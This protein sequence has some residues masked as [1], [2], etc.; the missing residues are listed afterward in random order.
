MEII[1][2]GG[3]LFIITLVAAVLLGAVNSITKPIIETNEKAA[4]EAAM[5]QVLPGIEEPAFSEELVTGENKGVT[6]YYAVTS[7]KADETAAYVVFV[8]KNGDQ[9]IVDVCVGLTV[10]GTV[11]KVTVV[12]HNETPGLGA[13]AAKPD[14]LNQFDNKDGPFALAKGG[15]S[16]PGVIDA[17]TAATHTS[18]AVTDAVN[19]AIAF[20]MAQSP[21]LE[22]AP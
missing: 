10:Q 18:L 20:I 22:V 16:G 21:E 4:K 13:N 15:R 6:S 8:T 5:I 17:V 11:L 14:F 7:G 3:K 1:K 2:T 9:G 19:D 12:N